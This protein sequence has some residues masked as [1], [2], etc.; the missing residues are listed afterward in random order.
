MEAAYLYACA[1]YVLRGCKE[2]AGRPAAGQRERK[3]KNREAKRAFSV[4]ARTAKFFSRGV[5]HDGGNKLLA[6][7]LLLVIQKNHPQPQGVVGSGAWASRT[8]KRNKEIIHGVVAPGEG[9]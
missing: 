8:G 1:F 6:P 4:I 2:R 7:C 3:T 9:R 5:L